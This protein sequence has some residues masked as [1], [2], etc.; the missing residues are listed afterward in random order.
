MIWNEY[1]YTKL[2][3]S[4]ILFCMIFARCILPIQALSYI[5]E[6]ERL[7]RSLAFGVQIGG[8][9]LLQVGK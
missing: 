2:T 5:F 7:S 8:D 3:A 6:Q 1:I 9:E 4:L